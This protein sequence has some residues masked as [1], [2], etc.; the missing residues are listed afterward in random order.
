[1]GWIRLLLALIN[2]LLA[3]RSRLALENVA[4]RQQLAVLR[5]SVKR[6]KIGD[7]DRG[8]WIL[9]R[10][11]L[12]RWRDTLLIVKPETVIKWGV[13]ARIVGL[14]RSSVQILAMLGV[15]GP[16]SRH[17]VESA[18]EVQDVARLTGQ[19]HDRVLT[20]LTDPPVVRA[21][22]EHLG[23]PADPPPVAPAR[24]PP[25]PELPFC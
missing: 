7:S 16:R 2:A 5:R 21:I 3:D 19:I 4:L 22:L 15:G 24:L 1:M 23:L 13:G 20:F 6:A 18:S 8:F 25:E 11:L 17:E 12:D 9:M 10:R 14:R